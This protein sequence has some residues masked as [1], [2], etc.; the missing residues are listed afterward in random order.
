VDELAIA[1]AVFAPGEVHALEGLSG[2]E[3]EA[4]FYRRWTQREA[5]GKALGL[6]L[7]LPPGRI[8]RAVDGSHRWRVVPL[9]S[10]RGYSAALASERG[11][12]GVRRW[13]LDPTSVHGADTNS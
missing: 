5:L 3:R 4:A 2:A 11:D 1:A 10:E 12:W 6:G 7:S 13:S 9:P 8:A